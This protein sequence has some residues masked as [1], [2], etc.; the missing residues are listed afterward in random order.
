MISVENFHNT[1]PLYIIP[2]EGPYEITISRNMCAPKQKML[3]DKLIEMMA[4]QRTFV[5]QCRDC[6]TDR[7]MGTP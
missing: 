1:P 4:L 7:N 3:E 6:I 5:G 2:L